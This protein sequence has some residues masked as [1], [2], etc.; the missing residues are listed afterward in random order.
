MLSWNKIRKGTPKTFKNDLSPNVIVFEILTFWCYDTTPKDDKTIF[1]R[2]VCTNFDCFGTFEYDQLRHVWFVFRTVYFSPN[3]AK[4]FVCDFK[5]IQTIYFDHFDMNWIKHIK[6]FPNLEKLRLEGC[7]H[8][9]AQF[10]NQRSLPRLKTCILDFQRIKG[11]NQETMKKFSTI[12]KL[13]IQSPFTKIRYTFDDLCSESSFSKIRQL[14]LEGHGYP[15][16]HAVK[17]LTNLVNLNL[18]NCGVENKLFEQG[19][20]EHLKTLELC[21]CNNLT[22]KNWSPSRSNVRSV[23]IMNCD[24]FSDVFFQK[25]KLKNLTDLNIYG[26]EL[27]T[28]NNWDFIIDNVLENLC[29]FYCFDLEDTLFREHA[30]RKL[31]K[32]DI[33]SCQM[34]N[35]KNWNQCIKKVNTIILNDVG[36]HCLDELISL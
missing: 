16:S 15:S 35:G 25:Q 4:S 9:S 21:M 27:I 7:D 22:G 23:D 1:N 33:Q 8:V 29:F 24:Y 20:F 18:V 13:S 19:S 31:K 32:L 34:I 2:Y 14:E 10:V 26:C 36:G 12:K 28:G 30:F 3:C 5:R 17:K 6:V 11:L